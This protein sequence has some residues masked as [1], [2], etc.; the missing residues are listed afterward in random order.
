MV[1]TLEDESPMQCKT[2][3]GEFSEV[4]IFH[5]SYGKLFIAIVLV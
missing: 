4:T 3:A 5:S 2:P 1:W